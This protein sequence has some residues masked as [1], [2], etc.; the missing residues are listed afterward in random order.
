MEGTSHTQTS[1]LAELLAIGNLDERDLVLA[2]ERDDELLVRLLLA[3][4]VEDAH[5]SLA[6]IERLAGLAQ[7]ARKTVVDERELEDA[8]ERLEDAHLAL[9]GRG[10]GADLD[11]LGGG[12]GNVV[13]VFSV[14][15]A[16]LLVDMRGVLRG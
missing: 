8:L 2:A 13:V 6:A 14:R 5:V 16:G 12:D 7:T 9:A 11:L 15:L 10:I 1:P 3:R 4:L